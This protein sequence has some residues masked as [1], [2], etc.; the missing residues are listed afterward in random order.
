[1]IDVRNK[2]CQKCSKVSVKNNYIY[3]A[4]CDNEKRYIKKQE[5][6]LRDVFEANNFTFLHNTRI[7]IT[8]K[9]YYNPDFLFETESFIFIVECDENAHRSYCKKKE[10]KRMDDIKNKI[11]KPVKFIRYNP[12]N[13]KFTDE[14]K[15]KV[16][17]EIINDLLVGERFDETVLFLFY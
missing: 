6:H 4:L 11:D 12:D 10:E 5:Y 14:H 3:C 1:M 7:T 2:K 15:E 16:L 9:L 8:K 13:K 17:I